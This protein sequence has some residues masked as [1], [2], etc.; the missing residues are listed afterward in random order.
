MSLVLVFAKILDM[1][2]SA[3]FV[4]LFVLLVRGCMYKLP[5]KYSYVLWLI[6]AIRLVCPAVIS[7]PFSPIYS[8]GINQTVVTYYVQSDMAGESSELVGTK[9]T[10]KKE[11]NPTKDETDLEKAEISESENIGED[12]SVYEGSKEQVQNSSVNESNTEGEE[13]ANSEIAGEKNKQINN[14]ERAQENN[15]LNNITTE[16]IF[17]SEA[18]NSL[19]SAMEKILSVKNLKIFTIIWLAGI[20]VMLAWNICLALWTKGKLEKAV[21]DSE[22]IYESDAIS[23]PFV[24]GIIK[25]RIYIPFR[26]E[27]EERGFILA[28]EKYHI[29]R[30]DYIVKLVAFLITAVYWFHPFVWLAYYC[31]EQDMEMSCDEQVLLNMKEDVRGKYSELLLAFATNRRNLS[32]GMLTFGENNTRK[33]IKHVLNFKKPVKWVGAVGILL[34]VLAAVVCLTNGSKNDLKE[35]QGE[36]NNESKEKQANN[37]N[38]TEGYDEAVYGKIDRPEETITLTVYDE[39]ASFSGTQEGWMADIL[40]EKFNVEL[41]IVSGGNEGILVNEFSEGSKADII[42]FSSEDTYRDPLLKG[43]LYNWEKDDLLDIYG[44]YMKNNLKDDL[45][46]NREKNKEYISLEEESKIQEGVY[47]I[48]SNCSLVESDRGIFVH[49]WD[50]RW[51]LYKQLGYPEI[52]DLEDLYQVLKDMQNLHPLDDNGKKAYA[53]SLWKGFF[54]DQNNMIG[55][56]EETISAY[57]GVVGNNEVLYNPETGE[58]HEIL[59]ENGP[60]LQV[61]Q[62]YNK[63]YREGMLDPDSK[64]L[65]YED[66]EQKMENG[67]ILFSPV[68]Y[69]GSAIYTKSHLKEGKMMT[70]VKPEEAVPIVYEADRAESIMFAIG[71]DSKYPE[72]AM[73]IINYMATPEGMLTILYGPKGVTWDYDE[74]GYT[75]LTELGQQANE[76]GGTELGNGYEGSFNDGRLKITNYVLSVDS[77]NP[78]SNGDCFNSILWKFNYENVSDIMKDWQE[79]MGFYSEQKYLEAGKS[80]LIPNEF[81]YPKSS[82]ITEWNKEDKNKQINEYSWKAIYA[83]SEEEFWNIVDQMKEEVEG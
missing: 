31:M 21:H 73:E 53:A 25:P 38:E 58:V 44:T 9:D 34:I 49:T 33:R 75:Y 47:G 66:M 28:H 63:L 77:T 35:I 82:Y 78:E 45:S 26:M 43:Q 54:S 37:R 8:D 3:T 51:D 24:W 16:K 42:L 56:I 13:P 27:A 81:E 4:V 74:E 64:K 79:K 71:K 10:N 50:I 23:S 20:I 62:W 55:G 57:F 48:R 67:S 6:V 65:E 72:I 1:S 69:L 15:S 70:S 2:I 32:P 22:N 11:R 19:L 41:N 80:V 12:D 68:N 17:L 30:K 5:K 7:L 40:L 36:K 52:K 46:Y 60:Y 83:E 18:G 61:L 14:I 76:D 29:K 39:L 59:E